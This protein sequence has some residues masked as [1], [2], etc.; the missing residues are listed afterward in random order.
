MFLAAS[1]LAYILATSSEAVPTWPF[2]IKC[3][4]L[5]CSPSHEVGS[6]PRLT[7]TKLAAL[8]DAIVNSATFV[9]TVAAFELEW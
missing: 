9:T 7:M 8:E 3:R 2:L 4:L 1:A 5:H 6:K